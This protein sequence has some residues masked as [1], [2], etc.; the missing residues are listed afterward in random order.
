MARPEE[1][2]ARLPSVSRS[3]VAGAAELQRTKPSINLQPEGDD[4]K[5]LLA[6]G[7]EWMV[8]VGIG[9]GWARVRNK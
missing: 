3:A 2:T 9:R 1:R 7:W 5:A 6:V 4:I 8:G